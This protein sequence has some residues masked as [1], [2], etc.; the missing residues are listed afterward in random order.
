MDE[1]THLSKK[2]ARRIFSPRQLLIEMEYG[3]Q[4]MYNTTKLKK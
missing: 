3:A 1:I 2:K 4:T